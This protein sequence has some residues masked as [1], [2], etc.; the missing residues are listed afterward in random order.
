MSLVNI[1]PET[2]SSL[3]G[4][5]IV[6]LGAALVSQL[7]EAGAEVIWGDI[8]S[9]TTPDPRFV[10]TD[11]SSYA[12]ILNLFKTARARHRH[13]GGVIDHAVC[14]AGVG[15]HELA[16][17]TRPKGDGDEDAEIDEEPS[18]RTLD[19]NL[20]GPLFFLRIAVHFLRR[21]RGHPDAAALGDVAGGGGGKEEEEEGGRS[22]ASPTPSALPSIMLVSS[23]AGFG[24]FAG[25]YAYSA[26]KHGVVGLFR[27]AKAFLL[28][29]EGIRTN[30]VLPGLTRTPM[31]TGVAD[32][33]EA[34]GIP[35]NAAEDV[36]RAIVHALASP[37]KDCSGEAYFVSGGR[38]YEI[39]KSARELRPRWLGADLD[40]DTTA[41][42]DAFYQVRCFT[43]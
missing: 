28:A 25:T 29:A 14:N 3:K 21:R 20:R 17:F 7:T 5:V 19:V 9:P 8:A 15:G 37:D 39:E 24:E 27:S 35:C 38:T 11:A 34:A 36:A 1:N 30:V 16:F 32:A 31:T 33:L 40:R 22:S 12:S 43:L 42:E 18:T 41:F 26:A 10:P 13:A 2:F 4:K 23:N 6:V